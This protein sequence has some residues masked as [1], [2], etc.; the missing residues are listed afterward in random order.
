MPRRP[1][2]R[3]GPVLLETIGIAIAGF[4]VVSAVTLFTA[5]GNRLQVAIELL[6]S[7]QGSH[8]PVTG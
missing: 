8:R 6:R 2:G 5:Y 7:I 4:A 1:G 3:H